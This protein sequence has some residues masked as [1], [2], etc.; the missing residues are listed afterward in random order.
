MNFI[1]LIQLFYPAPTTVD[2]KEK[3]VSA[4]AGLGGIGL[5]M[6]ISSL[7]L[8]TTDLPW[9]IASM[10]SSA[11][12]LYAVPLGPLS[13]PWS[14]VGGHLIS[15]FIGISVAKLVPDLS[16]AAALAVSLAIFAMYVT[17]CLHPP[18][19]ATALGVVV[20]G[21]SIRQLGYEYMITP[22]LMNVIVMLAWALLI[23]NLLANRYYPNTL[24][25]ALEEK[26]TGEKL[27]DL[28]LYITHEDLEYA[29]KSMNEFF[30]VSE[31]DLV[32]LFNMSATHARRK[33]M[34]EI[35]CRDVMTKE[36]I[37]IDYDTDVEQVWALI[38]KHKVRGVPVVDRQK[39]V[40]GFVSITN[41]LNQ[42][43][44]DNKEKLKDRLGK[45]IKRTPETTTDKPE[46]AGHLMTKQ[47]IT[48]RDDQHILELFP[49]F[50]AHDIH[51]LPVI[52]SEEKLCGIITPKNLLAALHA[53]VKVYG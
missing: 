24:K 42:V 6:Y 31:D 4:L 9:V 25:A 30:D 5:I 14:F 16:I 21:E 35:L 34:G 15:G 26:P 8:A 48:V 3:T 49:H 32:R 50:H 45:F 51:H 27:P 44:I 17:H 41:L 52:D 46:Y 39:K 2:L 23:N 28:S 36:V 1:R 20:G 47:V 43:K 33:R 13:Q 12:L 22:V 10:G 7:F 11:V 37:S 38:Q 53:D 40:I 29:M 18:G 19:G